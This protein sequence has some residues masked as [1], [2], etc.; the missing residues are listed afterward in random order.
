M[1]TKYPTAA[2]ELA[3]I[4]GKTVKSASADKYE[5]SDGCWYAVMELRFTDGSMFSFTMRGMPQVDALFFKDDDDEPK[6]GSVELLS[7]AAPT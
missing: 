3:K 2:E 1:K 7:A 4:S 6:H 5:A